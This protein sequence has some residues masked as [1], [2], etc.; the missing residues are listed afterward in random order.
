MADVPDV[1]LMECDWIQM[2]LKKLESML[3]QVL[4]SFLLTFMQNP[5]SSSSHFK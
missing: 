4:I 5:V 2:L 1:A 3:E